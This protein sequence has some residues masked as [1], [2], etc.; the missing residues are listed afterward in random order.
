[1]QTVFD[2]KNLA[3]WPTKWD[4]QQTSGQQKWAANMGVKH[5]L[6]NVDVKWT[7]NEIQGFKRPGWS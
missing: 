3:F 1:L 6:T 2:Q 5:P 7:R 4:N